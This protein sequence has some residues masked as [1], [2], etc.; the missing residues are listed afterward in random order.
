MIL[1]SNF[2]EIVF[3]K[4][5]CSRIFRIIIYFNYVLLLVDYE[6]RR[7]CLSFIE[8]CL[9]VLMCVEFEYVLRLENDKFFKF[10]F[11]NVFKCF[12]VF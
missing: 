1:I 2:I 6:Y 9:L 5:L 4:M 12:V 3:D 11:D 10:I 7:Y 8:F